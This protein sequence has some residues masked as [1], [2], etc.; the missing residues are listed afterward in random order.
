MFKGLNIKYLSKTK[1][2]TLCL[3]LYIFNQVILSVPI[4]KFRTKIF[5]NGESMTDLRIYV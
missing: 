5:N 3:S 2:Q 4:S 1:P